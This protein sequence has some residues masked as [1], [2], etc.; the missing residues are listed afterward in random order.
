[1][2]LELQARS[3]EFKLLLGPEMDSYREKM[4]EKV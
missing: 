3:C 4:L 2:V 1:M